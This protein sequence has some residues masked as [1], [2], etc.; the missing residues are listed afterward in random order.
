M[1]RLIYESPGIRLS[2]L[3][4]RAGVSVATAKERLSDLEGLGIVR[5]ESIRGG[6]RVLLRTFYPELER[7]EGRCAFALV[8]AERRREFLRVNPSLAGPLAQLARSVPDAV[9][10]VLVFGSYADGSQ[11]EG[12]DLD[13]LL[14]VDGEVDRESVRKVVERSFATFGGEVSPRLDTVSTYRERRGMGVYGSVRRS[15]VVVKGCLA[16]V[17]E[18][19]GVHD[20]VIQEPPP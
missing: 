5:E 4:R 12:S 14:L 9:R 10:V 19:I 3:V 16:Y 18:A 8:E 20:L 11:A 15:H 13:L 6:R 7:E 2:E 1:L 17:S